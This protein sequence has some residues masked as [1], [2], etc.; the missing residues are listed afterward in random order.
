MNTV[1]NPCKKGLLREED[2][3]SIA[4]CV[5]GSRSVDTTLTTAYKSVGMAIYDL[6]VAQA[7]HRAALAQGIGRELSL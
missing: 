4:E 1:I 6:C 2:V 3:F 7:L 5:V